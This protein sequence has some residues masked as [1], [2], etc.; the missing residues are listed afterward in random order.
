FL[1]AMEFTTLTRRVAEASGADAAAI[2]PA[3]VEVEW[4]ADAH[5][6]DMGAG[7]M[8][9][10]GM[11]TGQGAGASGVAGEPSPAGGEAEDAATPAS[12]ASA[13]GSRGEGGGEAQENTPAALVA[14]RAAEAVADRI[15]TAAY[16]C[17]RDL[18]TLNEWIAEAR[19]AGIVAFDTETTSLDPMQAELVGFS[20]AVR[21][22]RA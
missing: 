20:L 10:G 14:A 1:K 9:A 18:A 16:V 19:E 6:P 17:I 11:G 2:E 22:G 13:P 3:H 21:P 5:G 8:G 4:G 15:D 7:G 12:A